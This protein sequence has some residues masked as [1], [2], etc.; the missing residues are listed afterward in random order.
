MEC[1]KFVGS[2]Y[3]WNESDESEDREKMEN[4]EAEINAIDSNVIPKEITERIIDT[5]LM[6]RDDF[7]VYLKSFVYIL[8]LKNLHFYHNLNVCVYFC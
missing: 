4:S 3:S 1:P 5:I 2:A 7:K 6:K 8:I